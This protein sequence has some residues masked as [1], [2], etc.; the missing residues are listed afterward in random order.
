M[1]MDMNSTPFLKFND[2]N[3]SRTDLLADAW[4]IY[5]DLDFLFK[6]FESSLNGPGDEVVEKIVSSVQFPPEF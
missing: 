3:N 6:H 4:A 1:P 2:I 5:D